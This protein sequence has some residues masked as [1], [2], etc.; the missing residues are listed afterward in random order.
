MHQR[1]A[2]GLRKK[3]IQNIQTVT[4]CHQNVAKYMSLFLNDSGKLQGRFPEI[5]FKVLGTCLYFIYNTPPPPEKNTIQAILN[6]SLR[7]IINTFTC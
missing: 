2:E 1:Q 3:C 6:S 5:S 7:N 4:S